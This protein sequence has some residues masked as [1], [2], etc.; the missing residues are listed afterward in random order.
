MK[1]PAPFQDAL[2]NFCASEI[3]EF[4][5][6]NNMSF[7]MLPIVHNAPFSGK[8]HLNIK[9]ILLPP[10]SSSLIQT[11]D[12]GIVTVF[13][14]CCLKRAFVKVSAATEEDTDTVTE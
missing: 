12:K 10:N 4:V 7:K 1:D 13:K 5:L 3:E 2:L 8:L 9:V 6:E 11:M 14:A